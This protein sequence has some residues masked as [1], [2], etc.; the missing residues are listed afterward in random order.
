MLD[1]LAF[2]PISDIPN[3]MEH[4]RN[5]VPDGFTD[6]L[7]Y[8]LCVRNE[9]GHPLSAVISS[10]FESTSP[11]T[12][13]ST[14][15]STVEAECVWRKASKQSLDGQWNRVLESPICTAGQSHIAIRVIDNVRKDNTL[16]IAA[17]EAESRLEPPKKHVKKALCYLQMKLFSLCAAGQD[18]SKSAIEVLKAVV[19]TIRFHW[20]ICSIHSLHC[21]SYVFFQRQRYF[22]NFSL[23][24]FSFSSVVQLSVLWDFVA[25]VFFHVG[26]CP[27]PLSNYSTGLSRP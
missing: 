5:T 27:Y 13:C 19:H 15:I 18:G 17:L 21:I 23:Q 25:W 10:S 4:L 12:S 8:K 24:F 22:F 14:T 1:A 26:F 9:S 11:H 6:F 2:L 16:I 20:L 3:A 7:T